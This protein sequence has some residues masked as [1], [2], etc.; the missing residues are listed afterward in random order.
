MY[1]NTKN[2]LKY[3]F[4]HTAKHAVSFYHFE[5]KIKNGIEE[6]KTHIRNLKV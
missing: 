4:N 2:Y 1:F 3:I 5:F 6:G